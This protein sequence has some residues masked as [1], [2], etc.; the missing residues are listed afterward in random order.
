MGVRAETE[1]QAMPRVMLDVLS[2]A[3]EEAREI[4]EY[5]NRTGRLEGMTTAEP[6]DLG[7]VGVGGTVAVRLA[8][9]TEY[10]THVQNRGFDVGVIE[11]SDEAEAEIDM[12]FDEMTSRIAG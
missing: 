11:V 1:F 5:T 6:I 3:A 7:A 10:A 2:L 8:A 12:Q 9:D 4:H